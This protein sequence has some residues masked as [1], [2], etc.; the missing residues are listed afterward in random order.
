[1]GRL[2]IVYAP[3]EFVTEVVERPVSV[4][5]S[6]APPLSVAVPE[7]VAVLICPRVVPLITIRHNP[8]NTLAT[9]DLTT[10]VRIESTVTWNCRGQTWPLSSN[11]VPPLKSIVNRLLN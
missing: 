11:K 1:M 9:T 5:G 2:G 3:S 8:R 10:V 6:L 4:L 7:T